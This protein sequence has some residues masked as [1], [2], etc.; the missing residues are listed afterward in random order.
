MKDGAEADPSAAPVAPE[1]KKETT[2]N[3]A[4]AKIESLDAPFEAKTVVPPAPPE[5]Q[6]MSLEPASITPASIGFS[7]VE[8]V[9]SSDL[10]SVPGMFDRVT[11]PTPPRA[12][13][14]AFA[15]TMLGTAPAPAPPKAAVADPLRGATAGAFAK[16]MLGTPPVAPSAKA[17]VEASPAVA[18][19]EPPP[20]PETTVGTSDTIPAPSLESA[21]IDAAR[22]LTA[23][24]ERAAAAA[25]PPPLKVAERVSA[26]TSSPPPRGPSEPEELRA[27]KRRTGALPFVAAA[28]VIAGGT[29]LLLVPRGRPETPAA[30]AAKAAPPAATAAPAP[31]PSE[32]AAEPVGSGAASA[33]PAAAPAPSAAP[34]AA[35]PLAPSP[36]AAASAPMAAPTAA[37]TEAADD[38]ALATLKKGQGFLLV[39]SPIQT[40]VYVYGNLAGTTNQRITT[41]C[42]PR[43]L[44]LGTEPGKW[45]SEGWVQVVKCGALTRVEMKQ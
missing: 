12:T 39:A 15:K 9:H 17:A 34:S 32:P 24:V 29:A 36:A 40:N 33:A 4:P 30:P 23:E 5:G 22:A 6:T 14:G 10:E 45:Q 44:R 13:G 1:A 41:N 25:T 3:G 7:D 2:G 18:D 28:V 43:F 11:S 37:Q 21:A 19:T 31:S 35:E 38:A 42:G 20:P 27:S 8:E 16:T 26:D